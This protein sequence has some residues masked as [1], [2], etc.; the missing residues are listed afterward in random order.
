MKDSDGLCPGIGGETRVCLN[1]KGRNGGG[2]K[3]C[4][5]ARERSQ[6]QYMQ[7]DRNASTHKDEDAIRVTLPPIGLLFV[8][9]AC[10]LHVHVPELILRLGVYRF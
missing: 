5:F 7:S 9:Y 4:L 2:K 6:D 8:L 3:T 1:D 10:L